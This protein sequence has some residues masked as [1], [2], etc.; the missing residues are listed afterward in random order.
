LK[1][2][3]KTRPDRYR[4]NDYAI[5]YHRSTNTGK[6]LRLSQRLELDALEKALE[7]S[8]GAQ[9]VLDV[10]CGTGRIHRALS[11]RFDT[12]VGLD[13]SVPMLSVYRQNDSQSL[14]GCADIFALPFDDNHFDWVVSHR[15]F[16]HLHSDDDR[17]AVLKSLSRVARHGL[18]FYLW[19]DTPL[20]KRK[21]SMRTSIPVA[22]LCQCLAGAGLRLEARYNCGW[23]FTVKSIVVCTPV[24]Q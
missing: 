23:P 22:S 16:H 24:G 3:V 4:D 21:A 2:G 7:H 9:S 1:K 17:V 5:A 8:R 18:I 12:V 11:Q 15:Y 10:P 6:R 13:S 14:A 19:L 20:V